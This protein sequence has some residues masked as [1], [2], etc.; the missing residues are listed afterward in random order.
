[1]LDILLLLVFLNLYSE[2][3]FCCCLR[4][5]YFIV[6]VE[7]KKETTRLRSYLGYI[8]IIRKCNSLLS[9]FIKY[10]KNFMKKD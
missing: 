10:L 1:M 3:Y 4:V 8:L 7:G 5:V 6:K 9:I 2:S